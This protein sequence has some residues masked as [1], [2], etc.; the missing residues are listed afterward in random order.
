FMDSANKIAS[1]KIDIPA[2]A[3][4]VGNIDLSNALRDLG[5]DPSRIYDRKNDGDLSFIL[6]ITPFVGTGKEIGQLIKGE[7][8]VTGRKY[9]PEDYGWGTL[10]VVSGGTTRVIGKVVG[11]IGDLEKKGK[12]IENATKGTSGIGWSMPRGGGVIEGRKYT[13]HALE[14]MAPDTIQVR[15]ELT[16]RARERAERNGY[17]FGSKEYMEELKKVDP[18]GVTPSV[19]EETIK[20][21][22]K[23][24]GNKPGL[25]QYDGKDV[26]VVLN[27]NGD[28]V[29][30][31]PNKS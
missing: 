3:I 9:G 13:E 27:D 28:V 26:R 12:A 7:D 1:H 4:N 14:R 24:P 8:L 20:H 21:S 22:T 17:T 15:A 11:K 23:K 16:K 31:V 30:V 18:R 25:W 6:D 10:A 19:V 2:A 5:G 29:S